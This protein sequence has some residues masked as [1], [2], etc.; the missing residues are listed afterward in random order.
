MNKRA[1]VVLEGIISDRNYRLSLPGSSTFADAFLFI[2]QVIEELKKMETIALES[3]KN[4]DQ[5][6][7]EAT[8]PQS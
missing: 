7:G 2:D 8:L 4:A 3:Q 5:G 1:E 6:Q